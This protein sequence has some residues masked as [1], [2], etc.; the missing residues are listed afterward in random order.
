MGVYGF[1]N[2]VEIEGVLDVY[3]CL[4]CGDVGVAWIGAWAR[5]WKGGWCYVWIICVDGRSMYL[6]I[7]QGGT[8]CSILL[9]LM[10]I[11]F[12]PCICL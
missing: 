6:Y 10:D 9:Q 5:V 11:C 12:L 7:V 2:H 3:L 8:Q 1:S 4:G